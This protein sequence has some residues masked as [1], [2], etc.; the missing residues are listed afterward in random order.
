MSRRSIRAI[1]GIA[2]RLQKMATPIIKQLAS[3]INTK[4]EH[5]MNETVI[6]FKGNKSVFDEKKLILMAYRYPQKIQS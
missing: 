3:F 4:Q 6:A 1:G 5:I 2:I